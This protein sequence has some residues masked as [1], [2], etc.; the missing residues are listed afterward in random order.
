M[1]KLILPGVAAAALC[2]SAPALAQAPA[3]APTPAPQVQTFDHRMPMRVQTRNEVVAHAR[4]MFARLDSNR[5]G[6][7]TRAE[8]D[9]VHQKFA[10]ERRNHFKQ[11]VGER[12]GASAA[13]RG[14]GFDRLDANHDGVITRDEFASARP[15]IRE[16]RKIVMREGGKGGMRMHGMGGLHGRMFE[17]A[18]VNRDGRVSLQEMTNAALQHFDM[19]D[20][21]HDGQLTR[22]ER[23]Q[24]RQRMKAQ[25]QP[26]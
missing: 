13:D 20:A 17:R 9:A 5:D 23:M 1:K 16:Q 26:A 4:D 21:N 11:R 24:M 2:A 15:V 19:A 14:A 18:D 7:V 6:S 22:E 25:R 12:G 3:P 10:G 8:A